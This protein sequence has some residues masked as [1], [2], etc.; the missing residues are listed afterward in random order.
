MN[1]IAKPLAVL[2]LCLLLPACAAPAR[3]ADQSAG[4]RSLA[5][6]LEGSFSSQAQAR[7][8]EAYLDIRL[9]M[10][11]IWP[12]RSDDTK[13]YW[14]YVEQARADKLDQPYRQRV[15]HL[16]LQNDAAARSDVYE[17]PGDAARGQLKKFVGAD[18]DAF[19]TLAPDKLTLK[20]GCAVILRR[21]DRNAWSGGTIGEGC[22]SSLNGATHT[23][24]IVSVDLLG[25]RSWDRGFDSG[26]KQVWGAEKGPYEFARVRP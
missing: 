19:K 6:L 11:P 13:G 16:T 1:A 10:T 5:S 2:T 4:L 20:E 12:E 22:P 7:R 17:L 25:L 8:D 9:T 18:P 23:T 26:G 15:Y 21:V 24:S 3:R 14:F